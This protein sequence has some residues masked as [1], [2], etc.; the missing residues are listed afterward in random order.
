MPA[1]KS[2]EAMPRKNP[3]HS[4]RVFDQLREK[5]FSKDGMISEKEIFETLLINPNLD[6]LERFMIAFR[7]GVVIGNT[8]GKAG[9]RIYFDDK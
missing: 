5:A 4:K 6:E 8:M 1:F 9:E 7:L 3:E 2:E